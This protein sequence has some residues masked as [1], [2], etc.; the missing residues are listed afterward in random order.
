MDKGLPSDATQSKGKLKFPNVPTY[1]T[2]ILFLYAVMQ[3][4]GTAPHL[5]CLYFAVFKSADWC[6]AALI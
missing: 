3:R 4:A 5:Q 2:F 6:F 1:V